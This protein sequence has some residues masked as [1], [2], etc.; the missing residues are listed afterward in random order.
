MDGLQCRAPEGSVE[1]RGVLSRGLI[2]PDLC[3]GKNVPASVC[4]WRKAEKKRAMRPFRK[5]LQEMMMP[6][7]KEGTV[8]KA[9]YKL[10]RCHGW[11]NDWLGMG[12]GGEE[13]ASG[14]R[15]TSLPRAAG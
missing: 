11:R 4:N 12:A 14:V 7:L 1:H 2:G 9:P 13:G 5:L 6:C 15:S 10:V 3:F 8:K